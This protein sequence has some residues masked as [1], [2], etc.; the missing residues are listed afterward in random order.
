MKTLIIALSLLFGMSAFAGTYGEAGC[1]LG[2]I[3]MGKDGNQVLAATTNGT[4]YSNLFG[5]TSGTSN[6]TD[7]GGVAKNKEVPM[8]IEVNHMVLAK[9]AARGQGETISGLARLMGCESKAL[10]K[11][12]KSN[13][14]S[15][16]VETEMKP[17]GIESKIN[18]AISTNRSQSCGA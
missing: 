7:G 6:C 12:L 3:V 1:G 18:T 17:A 10:G 8:Y 13:Y 5:I 4:S 15:I 9:E 14:N 11:T 2:S 16:F